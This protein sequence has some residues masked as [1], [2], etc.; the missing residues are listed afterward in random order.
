MAARAAPLLSQRSLGS[1]R[2]NYCHIASPAQVTA[3]SERDP[4]LGAVEV[5]Y[6]QCVT[7]GER[8]EVEAWIAANDSEPLRGLTVD[9]GTVVLHDVRGYTGIAVINERRLTSALDEAL[10]SLREH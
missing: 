4:T 1:S 8:A 10:L 6:H 5:R 7:D 9:A 3:K 2:V